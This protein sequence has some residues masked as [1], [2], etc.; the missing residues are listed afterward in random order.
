MMPKS[1]VMH[2]IP[3][4]HLGGHFPSKVDKKIDA[5]IGGQ[6][7]WNSMKN[8]CQKNVF[9]YFSAQEILKK[10]CFRKKVNMLKW[11]E[12]SSKTRVRQGSPEKRKRGT[13]RKTKKEAAKRGVKKKVK[14]VEKNMKKGDANQAQI[15]ANQ[16][17][18][19]R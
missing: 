8:Q 10:T 13:D 15:T 7:W 5:K 3:R 17:S 14:K 16:V 9:F 18:K 19:K 1:D 4:T 2:L 6:K 12:S 11:Y